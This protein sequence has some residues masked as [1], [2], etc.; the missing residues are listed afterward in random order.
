MAGILC[1]ALASSLIKVAAASEPGIGFVAKVISGPMVVG[2]LFY[3]AAFGLYVL[4]LSRMP[5]NIAH[6]VMTTGSVVLVFIIS[7]LFFKESVTIYNII[8]IIFILT[9][10]LFLFSSTSVAK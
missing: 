7:S 9:G 8:G 1:N 5:L 3:V 2:V 6:P 10:L 4:A